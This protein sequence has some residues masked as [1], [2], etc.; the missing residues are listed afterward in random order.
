MMDGAAQLEKGKSLW[1]TCFGNAC[2]PQQ[3]SSSFGAC[4]A[5]SPRQSV[6]LWIAV[7]SCIGVSD[8]A[9]FGA[10]FSVTFGDEF[11]FYCFGQAFDKL[12]AVGM[13][14]VGVAALFNDLDQAVWVSVVHCDERAAEFVNYLVLNTPKIVKPRN[15]V[16][17]GLNSLINVHA[18]RFFFSRHWGHCFLFACRAYCVV[19]FCAAALGSQWVAQL[20]GRVW[21]GLPDHTILMPSDT[22]GQHLRSQVVA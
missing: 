9:Q 20:V 11:A 2:R 16:E 1:P 5:F 3:S 12:G 17:E 13:Q 22:D 21:E 8:K 15:L 4:R 14:V 18:Y 6:C 19:G 10:I 7:F